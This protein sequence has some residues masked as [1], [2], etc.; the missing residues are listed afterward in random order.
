MEL[1]LGMYDYQDIVINNKV[2][3]HINHD[4]FGYSF[5][6]YDKTLYNKPNYD[7]GFITGTFVRH[8]DVK[9]D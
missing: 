4:D 8:K 7:E 6:L 2:V 5:D 3:L 1:N 9:E